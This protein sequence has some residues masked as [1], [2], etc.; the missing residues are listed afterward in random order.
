MDAVA[1]KLTGSNI[2]RPGDL[3]S[4]GVAISSHGCDAPGQVNANAIKG[5]QVIFTPGRE[6]KEMEKTLTF[7][8]A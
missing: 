8:A 2:V 6:M 1:D 4:P 7:G 3:G 5:T